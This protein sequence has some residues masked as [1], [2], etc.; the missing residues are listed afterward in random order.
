MAVAGI[1]TGLLGI[2][3]AVA[4]IACLGPELAGR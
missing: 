1:I 4:L 3:L 2:V